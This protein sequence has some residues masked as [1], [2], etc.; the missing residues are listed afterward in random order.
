MVKNFF[1]VSIA[2]LRSV[3]SYFS[4]GTCSGRFGRLLFSPALLKDLPQSQANSQL[5][6]ASWKDIL[7]PLQLLSANTA[8]P[9]VWLRTLLQL[10]GVVVL[11]ALLFPLSGNV[12]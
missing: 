9:N 11:G 3:R 5:K 7:Q 2:Q 4:C 1:S 6:S 10:L 12:D 8:V